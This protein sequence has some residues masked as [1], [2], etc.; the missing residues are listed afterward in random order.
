MGKQAEPATGEG[1]ATGPESQVEAALARLAALLAARQDAS[2]KPGPLFVGGRKLQ[3]R[4][5]RSLVC[6]R[7]EL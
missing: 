1:G 5:T 7:G 4:Q 6:G 3:R 2:D